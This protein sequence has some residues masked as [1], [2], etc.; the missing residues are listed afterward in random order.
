MEWLSL[1]SL[2]FPQTFPSTKKSPKLKEELMWGTNR[3]S[4]ISTTIQQ[5]NNT[6]FQAKVLHSTSL[7][8][9]HH[10][11]DFFGEQQEI[12]IEKNAKQHTRGLPQFP[13]VKKK[14]EKKWFSC[15]RL[16]LLKDPYQWGEHDS[17]PYGLPCTF[18]KM[19]RPQ[20]VKDRRHIM[21]K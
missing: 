9:W 8:T 19:S 2:F 10:C 6:Q 12:N 1:P 3:S 5:W 16:D 13:H 15:D 21:I 14:R 20:E 4:E 18:Y 7:F 17:G 11:K